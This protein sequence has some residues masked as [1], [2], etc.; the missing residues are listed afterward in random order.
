MATYTP[1]LGR[2]T[3]DWAR[4]TVTG[5]CAAPDGVAEPPQAVDR[6][7]ATVSPHRVRAAVAGIIGAVLLLSPNS[8]A[9]AAGAAPRG[10]RPGPAPTRSPASGSGPRRGPPRRR[11]PRSG[12]C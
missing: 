8:V 5:C 12:R 9:T 4:F 10:R 11:R 6:T 3:M 7:T 2:A 1:A